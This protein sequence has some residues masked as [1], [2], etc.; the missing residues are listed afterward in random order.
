MESEKGNESQVS[1]ATASPA[2]DGYARIAQDCKQYLQLEKI[3]L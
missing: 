2:L 1:I 3:P